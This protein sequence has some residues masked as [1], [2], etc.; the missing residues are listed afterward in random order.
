MTKDEADY[1]PAG[2]IQVSKVWWDGE[3]LMA[4]P[5]PL[6]DI[7]QPAP[8][9]EPAE[10]LTGCPE[11]GMDSG[12]DCDSGTWNPP[13]ALVQEPVGEVCGY[14]ERGFDA[15]KI[16][17]G[18]LYNQDLPLGIKL[19]PAPP[20]DGYDKVLQAI[21]EARPAVAALKDKPV[22]WWLD[23]FEEFVKQLKEKNT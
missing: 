9:Q 6:E 17:Y 11:C 21:K 1:D 2:G 14:Y 22:S 15:E 12:C 16:R 8:V 3:K 7:Y 23:R 10:W 5:I 4:K 20:A 18:K 13:A 19:Y